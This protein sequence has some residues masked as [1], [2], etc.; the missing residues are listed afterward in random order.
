[1]VV[2]PSGYCYR[3]FVIKERVA[4]ALDVS[5]LCDVCAGVCICLVLANIVEGFY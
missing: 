4:I 1:M 5:V 3:C 2:V